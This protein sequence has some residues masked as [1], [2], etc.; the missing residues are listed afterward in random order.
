MR[1]RRPSSSSSL[2]SRRWRSVLACVI[3][4][5]WLTSAAA[6][7]PRDTANQNTPGN[8]PSQT[9]VDAPS[10]DQSPDPHAAWRTYGGAP[11]SAQY[12]SLTQIDRKNVTKL[13]V[14]WTYPSGDVPYTAGP[15]VVD[16]V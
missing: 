15:I 8:P 13:V 5:L 10:F 6:Q 14:A 1:L 12:S 3:G 2:G 4:A 7:P 16:G 9:L 11:D